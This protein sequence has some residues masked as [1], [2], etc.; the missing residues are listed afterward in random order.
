MDAPGNVTG[1]LRAW[2]SGDEAALARLTPIVHDELQRI[3]RR[4]LRGERAHHSLAATALVH[5]AY[6][7][8]VD[9][10]QVKWQDRT[11]FLAMAARLMRR[12]LVDAARAKRRH[13][14]GNGAV[15]VS[16]SDA[17]L[18][19]E[20]P[21]DVADLDLALEALQALDP[22]RS[23]V[24]ELRFFGGLTVAEI[25][26]V[27]D[28]SPETVMRDWKLARAWLRRELQRTDDA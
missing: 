25:G 22:R 11:H 17:R 21:C 13:K 3:A 4:C 15:Q 12:V 19:T 23:A 24:V 1:L 18:T 28:V 20:R 26:A 5:E 27:L 7:R 16:L 2:R 8:L 14:R 6:L 9:A 10:Q